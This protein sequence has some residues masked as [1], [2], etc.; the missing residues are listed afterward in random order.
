MKEASSLSRRERQSFWES[1][2]DILRVFEP[3]QPV[4]VL[5]GE[6][7]LIWIEEGMGLPCLLE[8]FMWESMG[9]LKGCDHYK[10]LS[11]NGDSTFRYPQPIT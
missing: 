5:G 1:F 10:R 7:L 6:L 9:L 11:C 8:L 4:L 3:W 2:R